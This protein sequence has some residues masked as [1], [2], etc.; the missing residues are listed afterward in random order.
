MTPQLRVTTQSVIKT[1]HRLGATMCLLNLFI[2][3]VMR[4]SFHTRHFYYPLLQS[5]PLIFPP[6]QTLKQFLGTPPSDVIAV[7][8]RKCDSVSY[9]K[10]GQENGQDSQKAVADDNNQLTDGEGPNNLNQD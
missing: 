1:A 5:I 2:S 9:S 6:F 8:G 4:P 7:L 10:T 3:T